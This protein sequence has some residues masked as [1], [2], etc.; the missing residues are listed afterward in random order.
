MRALLRDIECDVA[1]A[2][3][4]RLQSVFIGGGTP[5]LFSA[6]AIAELLDAIRYHFM[7]EPHAEITL[8]A[9][10]GSLERDKFAGLKAAGVNRLSLGV[11]SFNDALLRR[12]GRVHT[13]Q[14]ALQ[15]FDAAREAGFD[16]VNLD[17][18]YG[19]PGQTLKSAEDDLQR[20]LSSAPEHISYYQ[21]TIEP[22]TFF[23]KYQPCLPGEV[24]I[25]EMESSA[26]AALGEHGYH[27]YEVSAYAERGY[28]CRHNLNYWFYGDYLGVGAGAHTK[29][30]LADGRVVRF[31]K[32]RHPDAYMAAAAK[33]SF[34]GSRRVVADEEIVFEFVLNATRLT[35]GFTRSLFT[36]R[37]GLPFE[38]V[39]AKFAELERHGLFA[40][41]DDTIRPTSGGL[42]FLNE[43]QMAFLPA[44]APLEEAVVRQ[45]CTMPE[46]YRTQK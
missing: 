13:A 2:S 44:P 36:E 34:Y 11:Q 3:G 42:R 24:E 6:A 8:E 28:A 29:L 46:T 17:L 25:G 41:A 15:A 1:T 14:E 27:R 18:M 21:L 45:A 39:A 23:H 4:R 43:V 37:T 12:L 5:S 19:L 20:A 9:N 7:L 35:A 40:L 22:N 38:R 30:S 33:R 10:P 26:Y 31:V 32:H 16:N